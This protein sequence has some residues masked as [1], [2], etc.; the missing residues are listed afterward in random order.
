MYISSGYAWLGAIVI[1]FCWMTKG[2]KTELHVVGVSYR[3]MR[4]C[5]LGTSSCA[6]PLQVVCSRK[7]TKQCKD[8]ANRERENLEL[9]FTLAVDFITKYYFL[10]KFKQGALDVLIVVTHAIIYTTAW[11]SKQEEW[12]NSRVCAP[13]HSTYNSRSSSNKRKRKAFFIFLVLNSNTL[14]L[15]GCVCVCSH[16][17]PAAV[18]AAFA[19][20][21]SM[22]FVCTLRA[23][24]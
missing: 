20:H 2:K 16:V 6:F 24:S 15:W 18:N 9:R 1:G 13:Q 14:F 12:G 7:Q 21:F 23:H 22:N 19:S 5:S 8:K 4:L 11:I 10:A 17:S 3:Q